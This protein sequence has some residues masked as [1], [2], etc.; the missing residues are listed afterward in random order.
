MA[1]KSPFSVLTNPKILNYAEIGTLGLAIVT[2]TTAFFQ[3]AALQLAAPVMSLSLVLGYFKRQQMHQ[4]LLEHVVS[5]RSEVHQIIAQQD[6]L[7]PGLEPHSDLSLVADRVS[8]LYEQHE[9]IQN[10]IADLVQQFQVIPTPETLDHLH[11]SFAQL[12]DRVGGL[13]Q[14]N[15]QNP[16]QSELSGSFALQLSQIQAEQHNLGVQLQ[17]QIE[18]AQYEIS[19]LKSSLEAFEGIQLSE[20]SAPLVTPFSVNLAPIES[21][22]EGLKAQ[23]G[24]LNNQVQLLAEPTTPLAPASEVAMV[25]ETMQALKRQVETWETRFEQH[26][27][28]LKQ[29]LSAMPQMIEQSIEEYRRN[30]GSEGG[31]K[32][33]EMYA[34]QRHVQQQTAVLGAK[35]EQVILRFSRDI[36]T[37]S[38]QM[39]AIA[40]QRTGGNS[41]VSNLH[42]NIS[43]SGS[44]ASGAPSKAQPDVEPLI[45]KRKPLSVTAAATISPTA[46]VTMQNSLGQTNTSHVQ[47][48]AGGSTGTTLLTPPISSVSRNGNGNSS[49]LQDLPQPLELIPSVSHQEIQPTASHHPD[50]A[51]EDSPDWDLLL[52]ELEEEISEVGAA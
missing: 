33:E 28:T 51:S 4:S 20:A 26:R 9:A 48:R 8:N 37:L 12:T 43:S 31:V 1:R 35:L 27:A 47:E 22:I 45:E 39:Q 14:T 42:P 15:L 25:A 19:H 5:L 44:S 23:L 34:F 50:L 2:G 36:Q 10:A 30:H 52:A 18:E 16:G 11:Q 3:S 32:P 29:G 46:S 41:S 21:T 38:A 7:L 17:V 40:Q 49:L 24:T 13:Q 6:L